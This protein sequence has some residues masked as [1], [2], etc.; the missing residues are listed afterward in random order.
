MLRE[1]FIKTSHIKT[2]YTVQ[3]QFILKM[4]LLEHLGGPVG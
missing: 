3:K 2:Y 4:S 1:I